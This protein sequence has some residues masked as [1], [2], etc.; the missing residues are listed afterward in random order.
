MESESHLGVNVY[1]DKHAHII[2]QH[3]SG[4]HALWYAALVF[5]VLRSNA[6]PK[7]ESEVW[8]NMGDSVE[9]CISCSPMGC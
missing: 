4:G 2:V 7:W 9:P 1:K 6:G 3:A 5:G 8:V